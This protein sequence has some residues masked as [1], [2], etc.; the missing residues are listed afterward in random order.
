MGDE[1][2]SPALKF[3]P[4]KIVG[5]ILSCLEAGGIPTTRTRFA[6]KSLTVNGKPA[7]QEICMDASFKVPTVAFYDV[8][9]EDRIMA[10]KEKGDYFYFERKYKPVLIEKGIKP[11]IFRYEDSMPIAINPNTGK[12]IK[13][14]E[15]VPRILLALE[16]AE[17][18][19]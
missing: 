1:I 11:W 8:P 7:I 15:K 14:I 16:R 4:E 17:R 10:E 6:G 5:W 19:I 3:S 2:R 13:L 9:L 18:R 12:K